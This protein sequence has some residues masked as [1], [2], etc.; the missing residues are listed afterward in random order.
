MTLRKNAFLLVLFLLFTTINFAQTYREF[1]ALVE[2][3]QNTKGY[4]WT[5]SWDINTPVDTWQGVT[6]KDGHVVGLDLADNNL[7]G[8]I[9][10]TLANLKHLKHLNLSGNK[11]MGRLP[12][13]IGRLS[14]L[15]SL[16][17]ANN[18]LTGRIPKG[19]SKME[20]LKSLQ[21]G[22]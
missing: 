20:K 2:V 11:L 16:N 19:F 18:T 5:N 17:V 13:G 22:G 6:V 3:Y 8:K 10:L 1:V 12:G 21:F 7:E 4:N 15:H 9:P 14:K